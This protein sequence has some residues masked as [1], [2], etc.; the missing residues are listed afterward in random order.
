MRLD[1]LVIHIDNDAEIIERLKKR[2]TPLGFPFDPETGERTQEFAATNIWIGEQYLQLVRLL[3]PSVRGWNP[4]WAQCYNE[5]KRGVFSIFIAVEDLGEVHKG[6]LERD[7]EISIPEPKQSLAKASKDIL[8]AVTG[9]LGLRQSKSKKNLPWRS[10]HLPR[11]PGTDMDISFLEYDE[12]AKEE[13]KLLMKPNAEEYGIT[14][15]HRAKIYLP[16]WDEGIRFLQKVFPQL[17]G[18]TTQQK[19]ELKE[20]EL[21]FFRSDPEAGLKV[22]LEATSEQKKYTAK[23]FQIENLEVKTISA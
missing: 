9:F 1:H 13:I 6:L 17:I 5:G 2:V 15:I 11:I 16:L 20:D 18:A 10:L 8:Q 7:I 21:L 12:E 23:K 14:G 22:K 4:R 3:Q 19:V